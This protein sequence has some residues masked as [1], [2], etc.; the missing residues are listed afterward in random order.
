MTSC[1][2]SKEEVDVLIRELKE[3]PYADVLALAK[4]YIAKEEFLEWSRS[5]RNGRFRKLA[6]N[7]LSS[8]IS[9]TPSMAPQQPSPPNIS[10]PSE[11]TACMTQTLQASESRPTS[12]INGL[13]RPYIVAGSSTQQR[14][15]YTRAS[16]AQ[17]AI[18]K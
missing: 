8:G 12:M 16:P 10:I 14:L 5:G 1:L 17:D 11:G 6:R 15:P 2:M 4:E 18:K 3:K 13:A 9:M 7:M